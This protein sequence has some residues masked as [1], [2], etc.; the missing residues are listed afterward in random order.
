MSVDT[1]TAMGIYLSY[2]G[3]HYQSPDKHPANNKNNMQISMLREGEYVAE[4]KGLK[5]FGFSA[6][7]AILN[8]F[9]FYK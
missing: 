5:A 9:T 1:D 8:W 4:Y 7:S 3:Q 2:K 6:A